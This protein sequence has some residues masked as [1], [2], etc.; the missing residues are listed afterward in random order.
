MQI[1]MNRI[2]DLVSAPLLIALSLMACGRELARAESC[3]LVLNAVDFAYYPSGNSFVTN[4]IFFA[5][6]SYGLEYRSFIGFHIP[7]L[8][9]PVM[10]A[11]L[12]LSGHVLIYGDGPETMEFS[13]VTNSL[14]A[15][16]QGGSSPLDIFND[17]GD[18]ALFGY[19]TFVPNLDSESLR[20]PLNSD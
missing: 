20:I 8:G 16:Q 11:E 19:H 14:Q 18:G 3:P 6:Q 13:E 17:L 10:A 12:W 15:V 2:K 7:T 9:R 4:N 5:G 1:K